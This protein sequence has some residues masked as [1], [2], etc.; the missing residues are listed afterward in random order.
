MVSCERSGL[1]DSPGAVPSG[2]MANLWGSTHWGLANKL[3]LDETIALKDRESD[4]T[5][6]PVFPEEPQRDA[7]PSQSRS[8]LPRHR[9]T[10]S[11]GDAET[12]RNES[13]T[14]DI[15]YPSYYPPQLKIHDAQ[16]RLLFP[17]IPRDESLVLVFRATFSPSEHQEFPGRAYATTRNIYFYSN[18]AGLVL[19]SCESLHAIS[20]VT[21]AP[22]RDC[23]F[24]FFHTLPEKGCDVPGRYTVKT[25]LEPL[26]ILHKRLHFLVE[27]ASSG[28]PM[29]LEATI[30]TLSKMESDSSTKAS[31]KESWEDLALITPVDGTLAPDGRPAKDQERLSQSGVIVDKDFRL[32]QAKSHTRSTSKLRLPS[33]P[34]EYVPQGALLLAG[35]KYFNLSAKILFHVLFGDKSTVWH[36]LELQ[37]RAQGQSVEIPVCRCQY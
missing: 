21:A 7:A 6:P 26:R 20:E 22:G 31:S 15:H 33:Q 12:V 28:Q 17:D 1:L 23:D 9:Q 24:L 32:D 11:L 29:D 30:K 16:F 34:V 14:L 4:P 10:Q 25:F 13:K 8:T 18:Y 35:E 2:M 5:H 36:Q 27:N 37:R 19:T 3:K